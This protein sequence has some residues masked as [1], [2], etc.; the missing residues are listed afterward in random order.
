LG[1]R[2]IEQSQDSP[3]S[4]RSMTEL[5]TYFV[6]FLAG[7]NGPHHISGSYISQRFPVPRSSRR[8]DNTHLARFRIFIPTQQTLLGISQD[9][10]G[11]SWSLSELF[12]Q[13]VEK[14]L[15]RCLRL[16]PGY[17]IFVHFRHLNVYYDYFT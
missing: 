6:V 10:L 14:L 4:H 15:F 8:Q 12:S 11:D 1:Q 9:S 2:F 3:L 13:H 7:I 16:P 5:L 17:L